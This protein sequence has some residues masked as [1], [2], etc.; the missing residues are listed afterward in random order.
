MKKRFFITGV[1]SDANQT[2]LTVGLLAAAARAGARSLGLKPIATGANLINGALRNRAALLI[3]EA[4]SVHLPYEQTNPI[5]FESAV[6]PYVAAMKSNR[7][8]TVSRL[9]GFIKGAAAHEAAA[10]G[11]A[12]EAGEARVPPEQR[13]EDHA[14]HDEA[15]EARNK[16]RQDFQC[17]GAALQTPK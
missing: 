2:S 13:R 7:L 1:D 6:E 5:V 15:E 14:E 10:A 11:E 9:E 3:Q 8:V 4:S 12:G 16:L 17:R